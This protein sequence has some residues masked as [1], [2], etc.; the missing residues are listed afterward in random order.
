MAAE[1]LAMAGHSVTLYD[2]KPT[3]GRKFMMAG[4]GGLNITHSEPL[5]M[6]LTRY[7]SAAPHLAPAI[8]AFPPSALRA[9]CEGLGQET[10]VGTSGR[11]FPTTMKA[12]PLLR[13]WQARLLGLGVVPKL[14]HT[15]CG[16]TDSGALR[17]MTDDGQEVT[18]TPDA[19]LLALGGASWPKLGADG[20]WAAFL[21]DK[22]VAVAPFQPANC[23]FITAWSEIFSS[24]FAGTPLKAVALS[25]QGR[26]VRGDV[27]VTQQGVEGGAIYALSAQLREAINQDG[28][29]TL[30]IDLRPD[31]A[32][33]GLAQKLASA[34]GSQSLSTTLQKVAHLP[35]VMVSLLR[36]G[37]DLAK[38]APQPLAARIKA[39]PL[40][41]TAP[42]SIDRAISSAGGIKLSEVDEQ[43]MLK[44][45]PSVFVAGEMLDWEA[46]TGGYL[47]Q[48]CFSMGRA[49]AAGLNAHLAKAASA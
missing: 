37:A 44:A 36:E 5:E 4:R 3:F 27:M 48:A 34:R 7:G 8:T 14:Q 2:R 9:W 24:R 23:G 31:L 13:A 20:T 18:A 32:L 19:T 42:F 17:F 10:F 11:V 1:V 21:Q 28:A 35:P 26:T 33:E 25:H 49:A 45:L 39:F 22:G 43:F 12:S 41:L 16:F 15:W 29:T 47:L 38:L 30:L 46:P 6:F 40:T